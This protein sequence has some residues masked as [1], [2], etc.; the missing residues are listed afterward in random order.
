MPIP[1][2][3]Q[4]RSVAAIKNG[5]VLDHIPAGTSLRILSLLNLEIHPKVVTVG[6]NLPSK[7]MSRKDLIKF[8]DRQITHEEQNRIAILAPLATVVLIRNYKVIE[9]IKLTVPDSI[10]ALLVCPNAI[11][12]T[13]AERMDSLFSVSQG[14][15]IIHLTCV[16]CERTFQHQ[17]IKQYTR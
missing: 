8:E 13:N 15:H 17:D 4:T 7:R 2:R 1:I 3:K 11:C 5:T 6:L 14:G 10:S 12:I 9:K 16:Y